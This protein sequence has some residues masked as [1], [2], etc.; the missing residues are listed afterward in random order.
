MGNPDIFHS[1]TEVHSGQLTLKT[2]NRKTGKLASLPSLN[3]LS[4]EEE[5]KQY[6]HCLEFDLIA[7]GETRKES[8]DNLVELIF[9]QMRAAI[10]ENTQLF[11]PAPTPYWEKFFELRRNRLTQTFLESK[12]RTLKDIKVSGER[13]LTYA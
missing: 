9:E 6:L 2:R 10:E 1:G 7:D 8:I 5:G 4:W 11:H 12:P 3:C 13:A